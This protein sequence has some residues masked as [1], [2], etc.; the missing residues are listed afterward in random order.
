MM[1]E[2]RA[3]KATPWEARCQS[4]SEWMSTVP[5]GTTWVRV[6]CMNRRC[7]KYGQQQTVHPAKVC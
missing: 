2:Q 5:G 6:R 1:V 3:P 4:C 7:S